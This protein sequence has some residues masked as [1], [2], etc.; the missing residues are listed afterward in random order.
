MPVTPT[1]KEI[2]HLINVLRKG[3]L[4]SDARNECLRRASKR[5]HIGETKAG[6]PI[7]KL[8]WQ[9][10]ECKEWWREKSALEVDHIDEIGPFKGNWHD[11]INRMYFCGQKNLRALCTV[12]HQKKTS[13]YNA[14]LKY[15][16]KK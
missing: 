14:R 7:Y 15:K 4:S 5:V 1:K 10:A 8:H 13:N 6:K 12:C 9:C 2:A 11:F 16:R 3:T